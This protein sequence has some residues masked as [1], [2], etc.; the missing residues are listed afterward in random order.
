MS[1]SSSNASSL[2]NHSRKKTDS[3]VGDVYT[4]IRNL[5]TTETDMMF[6][7]LANKEKM[8]SDVIEYKKPEYKKPE[9]SE[10]RQ[11]TQ[12]YSSR[13]SK[14]SKSK[15]SPSFNFKNNS[16]DY[17]KDNTKD[18]KD[19]SFKD[20][21]YAKM[22]AM[23]KLYGLTQKKIQLTRNYT[24]QDSLEDMET[25]YNM[26]KGL[27]DKGNNIKMMTNFMLNTCWAI[28]MANENYNPFEFKLEGWSE[29]LANDTDEYY[30][31]FEEIYEKYMQSGKKIPPEIKL[32]GLLMFS[33]GKY[34]LINSG[35][36]SKP[37]DEELNENESLR[38]ELRENARRERL[39][40]ENAVHNEKAEKT[41][42]EFAKKQKDMERLARQYEEYQ[43]QNYFKEK[44]DLKQDLMKQKEQEYQN[45]MNTLDAQNS[46]SIDTAPRTM[47]P[48]NLSRI[49]KQGKY[50]YLRNKEAPQVSQI[51]KVNDEVIYKILT[52]ESTNDTKSTKSE[53]SYN[54]NIR[55]IL[56]GSDNTSQKSSDSKRKARSPAI[57]I[58]TE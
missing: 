41:R 23:Q 56:M 37:L 15:P 27:A 12:S 8:H 16:K 14:S 9:Y 31:V 5:R 18:S 6:E 36:K 35:L 11:D 29:Q 52:K 51:N 42:E 48:P 38:A 32:V 10:K 46:G 26:H 22:V 50:N 58:N 54:P 13:S 53:I 57:I 2:S 25:E 4:D 44:I 43:E 30:D 21:W 33:A 24:M 1:S 17:S 47:N 40:K 7:Y 19:K 39:A 55:E 20:E 49:H 45:L 34:G 28:E 3:A